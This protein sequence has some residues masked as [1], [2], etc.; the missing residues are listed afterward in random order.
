VRIVPRH[1]YAQLTVLVS[2]IL[3]TTGVVSSWVTAR[4][5]SGTLLALMRTNA[6]VVGM[7]FAE[8]AAHYL[9]LQDYAGLEALLLK[10]AELPDVTRLQV[11]EPDGTVVGDVE[12][13][14]GTRAR[15]RVALE[16]V[17]PPS[18]P[19]SVITV[20]SGNLIVWEPIRAG[21]AL[22]W[23]KATFRTDAIREAQAETWRNSLILALLWVAGSIALLLLVLRPATR[24][25]ARLSAFA[26]RLDERKGQRV[27]VGRQAVEIEELGASLNYASERLLTTEQQLV[28]ER[29]RL[30]V[31]LQSMHD[32]VIAA[33]AA[34]AVVFMNCAA[35]D[36]TGWPADEAR[37]RRIDEVFRL[38]PPA[39]GE[40]EE[41]S[42]LARTAAG[43]VADFPTDATLLARDGHR[44]PV[45]GCASPVRDDG[46]N[47]SGMVVVFRDV[48]ERKRADQRL[49]LLDFALNN[50][51]DEA[52]LID[53]R[54]RFFYVNDESCRALGW[55]REE[56]LGMSVAD[57]DPDLPAERWPG[58]WHELRERASLTFEGR[59]RTREG[60]VYPVEIGAN[61]FEFDGQGYNLA[62]ARDITERKRAEAA[63]RKREAE[64]NES[65]RLAHIGSWDWDAV[66]DSIWWSDEYYRIYG[67][68]PGRPSANYA[69]HLKAYT[70]ESAVRLDALVKRAMATGEPYEVDLELARPT[71]TTRW[72]VARGEPK[73][74]PGGRIWG[75]RGT[76]QNI[77]ERKQAEETLREREALIRSILDSVDEGFIVVD[78]QLRILSAN[79]AFCGQVK[80]PSERVIGSRCHEVTH[81]SPRPCSESGE[82]CPVLRTFESGAA[83]V[84][85]H[86]HRDGSGAKRFVE[87]KS[88]PITDTSGKV[89]SVIETVSDVTERRQLEE[90]LRQA[91]KMEAIGTLA[92]GVAHDFN[93]ILTAIIGY[94]T[95]VRMKMGPDDPLRTPVDQILSSGERAAHLTQGLLAFSRKQVINPRP[96]DLNDVIR[97]VEKLL[98]RLI[99][100]DVELSTRLAGRRLTVL[101]DASQ[102]EQVLMNLATNARDAMPEGGALTIATEE[103]DVGAD[104]AAAH[105]FGRRGRH[106]LVSVSD[107]GTGMDEQTREKIFEPFFTTKDPGR[108]TGLG[109]AIVYGIV[110]QH[111]GIIHVYSE[112]GRGT[113]FKIYLPLINAPADEAG[114]EAAS[115]P[116]GGTETI[117][118]AEDDQEVRSLVKTV[119]T[120]FGY[121]VLAAVDGQEAIDVLGGDTPAI[122]L[123][124]VDVIMPKR[125]G[126]DVAAAARVLRPGIKVVF[127]SGYPADLVSRKGVFEPGVE[128]LSKP[129]SPDI[130]LRKLREV[131]DGKREPADATRAAAGPHGA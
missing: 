81:H 70:A 12:R 116:R 105:G 110:K 77:T 24:A 31:T 87:V 91:Q 109:L 80:S 47:L 93:N 68:E 84:A 82:D 45:A 60:H 41:Q 94:G 6:A 18:A 62:L 101:A 53:E 124:L 48:T 85:S 126:D 37:G 14:P 13:L 125:S 108:G 86:T 130:L 90:Q 21:S 63:L 74:E 73:R 28:D 122:D 75:L 123:L 127:T 2:A 114:A 32:A 78:R 61:Y 65:Q 95:L 56:L 38:A 83:R 40:P 23:V 67:L 1:L 104:F 7:S 26:R 117:L 5:Q 129:V 34:R 97:S 76:A 8:N 17:H 119:L 96:V 57:V 66:R 79:R 36:L 22:G 25:V 131:L 111:E 39:A 102:F 30:R 35:A 89:T 9:V 58:H 100:E 107:T 99:G 113:T 118:L 69:E 128:F 64:L 33:D 72:V 54:G 120:D 43:S 16:H 112:P 52:Y 71:A 59:H 46:G 103:F 49:T 11:C 44:R 55:S 88:Y 20:E 27:T 15:A 121:R 106:A 19:A 29:E 10:S 50:V 98:R 4:H 51:R 115:P 42:L 92:G 3:L